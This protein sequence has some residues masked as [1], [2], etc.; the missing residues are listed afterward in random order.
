[1]RAQFRTCVEKPA[2]KI[3]AIPGS[4]RGIL[5][6]YFKKNVFARRF[7]RERHCSGIPRVSARKM[8][9]PGFSSAACF[10]R[11]RSSRSLGGGARGLAQ[12]SQRRRDLSP[13]MLWKNMKEEDRVEN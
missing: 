3:P 5:F 12:S 7:L 4:T 11:G 8:A 2:R 6:Y 9:S 10:N 1:M 13:T